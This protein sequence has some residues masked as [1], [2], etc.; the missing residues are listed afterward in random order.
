M[1]ESPVD[2][3]HAF[4]INNRWIVDNQKILQKSHSDQWIAVLNQM[5]VDKDADLRKLVKRLKE[6][7]PR[8]YSQIAVEYINEAKPEMV[9]RVFFTA[10]TP[11]S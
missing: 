2:N 7:H 1:T 8:V 11:A 10:I 3:A 5:V 6:N 9:P 4:K